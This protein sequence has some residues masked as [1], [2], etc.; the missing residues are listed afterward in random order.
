MLKEKQHMIAAYFESHGISVET[1][2]IRG[3]LSIYTKT[4]KTP[5]TRFIPMGRGDG[6]EV[7][8]YSHSDKWDHIGDFGGVTMSLDNAL[9]YVVSDAPGCFLIDFLKFERSRS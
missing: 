4:R 6:V 9:E 7:M 8:W 3:G 2:I 5:I 1:R